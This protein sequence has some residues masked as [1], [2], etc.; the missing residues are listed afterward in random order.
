MHALSDVIACQSHVRQYL[1]IKTVH[2]MRHDKMKAASNAVRIREAS[3]ATIIQAKCRTILPARQYTDTKHKLVLLQCIIRK[4]IALKKLE[5]LK[6][7]KLQM[8]ADMVTKISSNWKRY[9]CQ[10]S[11]KQ[12]VQ[13]FI[14]CQSTIRRFLAIKALAML[15]EDRRMLED[16]LA[17]RIASVWRTYRVRSGYMIVLKGMSAIRS[18]LAV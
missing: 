8:Q 1:A 4:L 3:M 2:Q 11:F 16:E 5:L 17:T 10:M 13:S 18:V 14:A 12:T 7:E 15:K 6:E 9:T